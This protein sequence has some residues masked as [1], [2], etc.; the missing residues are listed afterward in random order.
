ELRPI[1]DLETPGCGRQFLVFHRE[2]VRIFKFICIETKYEFVPW[3][4]KLPGWVEELFA[5]SSE[6]GPD[7]LP[8]AYAEIDERIATGSDDDLGNFVEA[9]G[10][11]VGV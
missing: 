5:N 7:F 8:L 9:T 1:A 2:M 10:L 6:H 4:P 11:S 3:G